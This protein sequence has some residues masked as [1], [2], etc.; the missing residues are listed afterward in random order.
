MERKQGG[1]SDEQP[2]EAKDA[3]W[4]LCPIVYSSNLTEEKI[5]RKKTKLIHEGIQGLVFIG[6]YKSYLIYSCK[7]EGRY[8]S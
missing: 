1:G 8:S 4:T 2:S 6:S 5:V 3:Y 7:R